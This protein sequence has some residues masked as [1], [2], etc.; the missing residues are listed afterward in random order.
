M[1]TPRAYDPELIA[2][3]ELAL[4]NSVLLD[5]RTIARVPDLRPKHFANAARAHVYHAMVE[6]F[7]ASK[8]VDPLTIAAAV[9]GIDRHA[10][11]TV[12]NAASAAGGL[13]ANAENS[14]RA[15]IDSYTRTTTAAALDRIRAEFL[16][17]AGPVNDA[18][19]ACQESF[20][21]AVTAGHRAGNKTMAAA[22]TEAWDAI[23]AEHTGRV[24]KTGIMGI[25]R[26]ITGLR[27]GLLTVLAGRPSSGKSA[28]AANV[29]VNAALAG[30]RT[31]FVSL[32]DT[33]ALLTMRVLSR[34][35]GVP[36]SRL[37]EGNPSLEQRVKMETASNKLHGLPLVIN[38]DVG[39][40]VGDVRI[41]AN[42]MSLEQGGLGLVVIDHLGEMAADVREYESVSAT[43]RACRDL[44]KSLDVPVLLLCQLNRQVEGRTSPEPRLSDLRGSG[45]IEE[46][47]RCVWLV[48]RVG[49]QQMRVDIAKQTHGQTGLVTVP[50]DLSV[51]HVGDT[52]GGWEN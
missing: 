26:K 47:A 39:Q 40:S 27:P 42:Q 14:A 31:L 34:I 16:E 32:E 17:H 3:H 2:Q 49:D 8:P 29:A 1:S 43:V 46:M 35:S 41:S 38:D 28:L 33:A 52:V 25:D 50:C 21:A 10:V 7:A 48:H 9:R 36:Y 4:V 20:S 13:R 44:A 5:A 30:T 12:I 15:I 18:L 19:A 23:D 22:L 51:M 6:L 37:T 24:V 45:K 11:I